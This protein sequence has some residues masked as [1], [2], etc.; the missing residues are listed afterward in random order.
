MPA[1]SEEE[2]ILSFLHISIVFFISEIF[3]IWIEKVFFY[4]LKRKVA[5]KSLNFHFVVQIGLFT[6]T[7][8]SFL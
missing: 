4:L 6:T 3:R 5:C 7:H 2:H 1:D 8:V